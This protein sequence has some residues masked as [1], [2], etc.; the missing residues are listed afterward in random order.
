MASKKER[1]EDLIATA[2]SLLDDEKFTDW[3]SLCAKGFEYTV[4]AYSEE[5]GHRMHW[6][7]QDRT[8]LQNLIETLGAHERDGG[9]IRR[10]VGM[11]RVVDGGDK[12]RT[13]SSVVL[14]HIDIHGA[15]Q[16]FAVGKYIDDFVFVDDHLLFERREVALDTRRLPCPSHVPL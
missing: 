15:T 4:T 8:S 7:I 5:I 10:H 1:I 2:S 11:V 14:W 6:M 13:E 12:P 3:I 16:L 9:K